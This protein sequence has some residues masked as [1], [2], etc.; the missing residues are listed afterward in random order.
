MVA[1]MAERF[2]VNCPLAPGPVVLQG[3]EAHHLATV[4][5]LRPADVVCLFN[6]DGREYRATVQRVE[7]RSVTLEVQGVDEPG[8]ELGI[9]L[10]VAAPLPR[11]DRSQF[12]LE[13]LAELGASCFVPLVTRYSVI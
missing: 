8:R 9:A 7:R 3:P 4:C 6:G 13:K 1:Q 5:R 2:Y 10:Y 11:G 12:L